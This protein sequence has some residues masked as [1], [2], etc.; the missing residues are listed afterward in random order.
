VIAA[1]CAVLL[2]A[3]SV[4][5]QVTTWPTFNSIGAC[6]EAEPAGD[7]NPSTADLVG[8]P[9]Q[10]A[11]YLATDAAF[12]YLRERVA[13]NPGSPPNL[14]NNANWVVLVQVAGGNPFTYQYLIT[15]DGNAEQVILLQ[16]DQT[17]ASQIA[18]SPI[19]NDPAETLIQTFPS[20]GFSR[21][22]AAGTSIGGSANY[23]V[24][25]A[26]PRS[27]LTTNGIVPETSLFWFA[28]SANANNYN[29]DTT[30]CP[31]SPTTTLGLTKTV[32]PSTVVVGQST[33]VVYTITVSNSGAY[34][35]RCRRWR[36]V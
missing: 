18:F 22:L 35:A 33:P 3:S 30:D 34:A 7:E 20:T 23:F 13:S 27:V 1:F 4:T 11:A 29:K 5:A 10:S 26:I 16:N 19:F 25:W 21:T 31:F 32:N 8:A 12:L 9:G 15:L 28:T 2:S 36:Q 14:V 17:T 6:A 24:D